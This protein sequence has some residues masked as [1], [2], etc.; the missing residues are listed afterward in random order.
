MKPIIELSH[1]T[2]QFEIPVSQSFFKSIFTPKTETFTAVHD[3]SL[4]I[5]AGESVALLGPNG[6][7][8]TTTMKMLTGILY[9]TSGSVSLM[10]Y[11]PHQRNPHMLRSIGFV[12]GNKTTLNT[13]LSALQN[14]ELSKVIYDIEPNRFYR[15]I[16]EL[17]ELLEVKQHL[18]KQIR[19]LSLGQRMKVELINSIL[20]KPSVLFLDEPTIGLDISSQNNIRNFL[21]QVHREMGTTIILTSHNMEDIEQ[22]SDR[23][24]VINH[25]ELVFDNSLEVL[26]R[27]F[28]QKKYI[29]IIFDQPITTH[30]RQHIEKVGSI[31]ESH[32]DVLTIEIDKE[33]QSSAITTI[34]ATPHVQDIDIEGIPLSKIIEQLFQKKS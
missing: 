28:S 25:G 32:K 17:S 3:V 26:K 34:L 29:K 8:K 1:L 27:T 4:T 11:T 2:K 30:E 20:H 18:H 16:D 15:T 19:R 13:D 31:I 14:Y 33:Q 23:V 5:G 6:A 21:R 24:I 22:V 12:M 9:P 7:G 10:G